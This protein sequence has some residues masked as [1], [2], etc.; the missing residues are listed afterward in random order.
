ME[1]L[2][3]GRKKIASNILDAVGETPMVTL[4]PGFDPDVSCEV[5]LKIEFTNPGGSIKDRIALY[6]VEQALE[7]GELKP[8]GRIIECSSGNTGVGLCIVA[9]A[10]GHPITIVIPDK[11][12]SEKISVL[13][14]LGAE[15]IV[16]PAQAPIDSPEHYTRVAERLAL[17]TP[18]AW[19]PNQYHNPDN[20]Q[21][22]YLST[23][24]E[25]WEQC[26]GQLTAFVAGA[27]T[28]GSL[29]GTAR[30]LKEKD[31]SVSIVGVDPPGSILAHFWETGEICEPSFYAVEGVGE[32]EVPAA[33]D[34]S[35]ID[36]YKVIAD[37][38][39]FQ[40]A[41][42]L[43]KETGIFAG[44]SSGMNL[45]AA[46]QVARTLPANARVV[47]L[48]PDSGRAYLSKVHNDDWMKD[49]G[50]LRRI[51]ADEA[52][53]GSLLRNKPKTRVSSEDTLAWAIRQA[54]ELG[55]RPLPIVDSKTG[56]LRGV[57]NEGKAIK[58]LANGKDLESISAGDCLEPIPPC[59]TPEDTIETALE[60]I[61]TKSSILIQ[62][63]DG[64]TSLDSRDLLQG[65]K[66]LK[67]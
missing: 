35:L 33:W 38:I 10:L 34:P 47:T 57:L 12:S 45:A 4:P 37:E 23:G 51:P 32:E 16:T 59:F 40:T 13:E 7:R 42:K 52:T 17:E 21:A 66:R 46:L 43:A 41:R 56:E 31:S 55:I 14:A 39:S 18:G 26:E 25:I 60:A 22:H 6:M 24:P 62:E 58:H 65:L 44:G 36:D 15:V 19:C 53:L 9:A 49:Q 28:G 63:K 20:T 61:S 27:G 29:T 11:M 8:G 48:L 50:Y 2:G 5:L 67:R 54:G 30:F 1:R 64:W 3:K